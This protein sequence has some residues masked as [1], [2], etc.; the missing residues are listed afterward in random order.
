M[1]DLPSQIQYVK[2]NNTEG[3]CGKIFGLIRLIGLKE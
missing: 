2:Q 3:K 1:R